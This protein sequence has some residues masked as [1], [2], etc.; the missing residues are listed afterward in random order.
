MEALEPHV[1]RLYD[2]PG[3]SVMAIVE[4]RHVERVQV[5]PGGDKEPSVSVK[6]IGCEVPNPDQEGAIR[7]A[8]R[9]L[10]LQRTAKG[11]IDEDGLV[12]LDDETMRR[13]GGLLTAIEVARL[14]AG[15]AHWTAY[16][17]QVTAK[18]HQFSTSEMAHEVDTIAAGLTAVFHSAAL[19][20]E[21]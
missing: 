20:A 3:L 18:S 14:R 21:D 4:L 7:E 1:Q 9:A 5:A 2:R 10:F 6:M 13:T 19:P 16:A 8:Q 11:T 12:T 17:N 15:L